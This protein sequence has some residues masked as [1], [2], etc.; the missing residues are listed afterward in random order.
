MAKNIEVSFE[1]A[2]NKISA[3]DQVVYSTS[4]IS[5]G[6][7]SMEILG[8][9]TDEKCLLFGGENVAGGFA[10]GTNTDMPRFAILFEQQTAAGKKILHVLYNASFAPA[11]ISAQSLEEGE[12]TESTETLEFT[13]IPGANNLFFYSLDTGDAKANQTVVKN[14]YQQVQ[15]A[16]AVAN[17]VNLD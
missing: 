10:M 13:C 8:L 16:T 3:D 12:I 11:G 15:D 1:I 5:S 17:D 7:G 2:E 4:I 14:W 6:N 9:T